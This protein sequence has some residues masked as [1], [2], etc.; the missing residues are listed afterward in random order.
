MIA[1]Q[2][3]NGSHLRNLI[4]PIRVDRHFELVV[5]AGWPAVLRSSTQSLEALGPVALGAGALD[6]FIADSVQARLTVSSLPP[7]PFAG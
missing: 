2:S 7:L 6:G 4:F 5:R 1:P 3:P